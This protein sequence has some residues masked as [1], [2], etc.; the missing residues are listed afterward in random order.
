MHRLP[1][2]IAKCVFWSSRKLTF[3]IDGN[4]FHEDADVDNVKVF[5]LADAKFEVVVEDGRAVS[6]QDPLGD[7]CH[8]LDI[9]LVPAARHGRSAWPG[10]EEMKTD[11]SF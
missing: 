2:I 4:G 7:F 3:Y 9:R 5:L 10:I 6:I 8:K 1:E 11:T